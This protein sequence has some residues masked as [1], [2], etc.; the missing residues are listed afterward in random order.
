MSFSMLAM[1]RYALV[2]LN[3]NISY[4]SVLFFMEN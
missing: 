3:V 2:L 4:T 1:K